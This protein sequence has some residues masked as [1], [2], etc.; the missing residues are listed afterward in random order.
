VA[1]IN[2][3]SVSVLLGNGGGTFGPQQEIVVGD[4]PRGIAVLDADGDG[5]I[6]IANTNFGSS[7]VSLLLNDGNGAFGSPTFFDGGG[8]GEW[9]LGSCDMNGDGILDLVVGA[10]GPAPGRVIVHRGNGNGTFT[11]ISSQSS[12]GAV[13]MLACGDLDGNGADDVALANSSSN[14]GVILLNDGTGQLSAPQRYDG[15]AFPIASD[16]G[17]LDGDNDLDW[18]LSN[19]NGDWSVYVN[20]GS[21]QFTRVLQLPSTQAASCAIM[22]DF[23]SDGDLDLCL[24]DEEADEL[25]LQKNSGT[26]QFLGDSDSDCHVALG[27]W[28]SFLACLTGPGVCGASSCLVFDYDD[29]C[30][31]DGA[32]FRRFQFEFTG[33]GSSI[34]GCPSQP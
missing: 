3:D 15:E 24:V 34:P 11:Q 31:L 23:D 25:R 30:D 8:T 22:L 28:S 21:G 26:A 33:V 17:D 10:R 12:D 19:Y 9:G 16:V 4:A 18:V 27:D 29:D 20:N 2:T 14:R 7:N 32:D 13:W 5:D 6:D 1:N